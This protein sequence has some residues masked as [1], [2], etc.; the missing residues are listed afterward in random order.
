MTKYEIPKRYEFKF[1]DHA[2]LDGPSWWGQEDLPKKVTRHEVIKTGWLLAED[3]HHFVVGSARAMNMDTGL[4]SF[5]DVWAIVK[6]TM[7]RKRRIPNA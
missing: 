3:K 7:I 4:C 2:V 6:S 5:S 1:L